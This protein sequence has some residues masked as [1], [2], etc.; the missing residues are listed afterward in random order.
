MLKTFFGVAN[1]V[2]KHKNK[3][4][5]GRNTI[6]EE[7]KFYFT[8]TKEEL[9]KQCRYYKG[10]ERCPTTYISGKEKKL[11][12]A[13]YMICNDLSCMVSKKNLRRS[14]VTAVCAYVEKWDPYNGYEI[15]EEYIRETG[16]L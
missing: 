11:W 5:T 3:R 6:F 2:F 1:A 4:E 12:R 9:L 7:I 8:M 13:E 14:F 10:E 15:V 16:M